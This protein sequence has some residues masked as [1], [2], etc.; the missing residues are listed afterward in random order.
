MGVLLIAIRVPFLFQL[1]VDTANLWIRVIEENRDTRHHIGS[2]RDRNGSGRVDV[3]V[4]GY[5]N[6]LAAEKGKKVVGLR[7]VSL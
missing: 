6:G 7:K 5:S 4:G 2:A 3:G 1:S